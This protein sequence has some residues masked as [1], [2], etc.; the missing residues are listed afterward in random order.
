MPTSRRFGG[1]SSIML[2]PMMSDCPAAGGGIGVI[3]LSGNDLAGLAKDGS[4]QDSQA[5]CQRG[6]WFGGRIGGEISPPQAAV[7]AKFRLMLLG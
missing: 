2:S 7:V 6:M 5:L 3:R 4:P 1:N